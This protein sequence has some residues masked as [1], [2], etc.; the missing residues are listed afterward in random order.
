MAD[1]P[2]GFND[3]TNATPLIRLTGDVQGPKRPCLVVIAGAHLGEIFP[4]EGEII[5]GRD[6]EA[7]LR[8]A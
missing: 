5:I 1:R 7:Q 4:V 8:L 6:P 3:E 2:G